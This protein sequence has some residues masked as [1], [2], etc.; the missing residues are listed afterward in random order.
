[1]Y[2]LKRAANP[3]I[4]LQPMLPK[5]PNKWEE[6]PKF[7]ADKQIFAVGSFKIS[8]NPEAKTINATL[9]AVYFQQH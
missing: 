5:L 1:M 2:T 3:L 7:T 9:K 8:M 6:E 4:F